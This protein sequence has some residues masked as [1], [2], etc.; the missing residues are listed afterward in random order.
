MKSITRKVAA[1][2][3]GKRLFIRVGKGRLTCPWTHTKLYA[4]D[5]VEIIDRVIGDIYIPFVVKSLNTRLPIE[6]RHWKLV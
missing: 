2:R 1:N 4:G 3:N 6:E 5:M